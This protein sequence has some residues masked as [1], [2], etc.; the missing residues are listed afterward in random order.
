MDHLTETEQT[1]ENVHKFYRIQF[2]I[3][4]G[5]QP[6]VTKIIEDIEDEETAYALET[7]EILKYGRIGFENEGILTNICLGANPPNH[8]GKT[9]S[10]EHRKALSIAHTGKKLSDSTVAKILETKRKNGTL[11][12]G[13]LG[14]EHCS[15]TKEKI[16]ESKTGSKMTQSS[17]NK[18][19]AALKGKPWSDARKIAA[20][21]QQKT[22]PKK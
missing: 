10:V 11:T 12:S 5:M 8:K 21:T 6:I 3:N 15:M 7:A 22:G 16:R 1:T 17:S 19:S 20:L 13:M 18:K 4:N 2:L 14:K 9:K